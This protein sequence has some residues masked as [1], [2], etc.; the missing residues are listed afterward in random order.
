MKYGVPQGSIL[1]PL[2]FLLFGN[3]FAGEVKESLTYM[4]A[5]DIILVSNGDFS[6]DSKQKLQPT[7]NWCNNN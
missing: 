7:V 6:S 1:G 3:D 5:D 2:M 4:N